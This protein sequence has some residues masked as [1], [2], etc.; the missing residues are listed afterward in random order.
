[1]FIF[2]L[3]MNS[4]SCESCQPSLCAG[5]PDCA[6]IRTEYM[7]FVS[8]NSYV[9]YGLAAFP[10]QVGY[11]TPDTE[12]FKAHCPNPPPVPA[13]SGEAFLQGGRATAEPRCHLQ[14]QGA[15]TI[16][17]FAFCR[18]RLLYQPPVAQIVL[19]ALDSIPQFASLVVPGVIKNPS[20]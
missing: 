4:Q 9:K 13:P 20:M 6:S 7:G 12:P 11:R 18:T 17:Q 19:C 1:M 16:T 15:N 2:M 14:L 8:Y 3:A 5:N 10:S